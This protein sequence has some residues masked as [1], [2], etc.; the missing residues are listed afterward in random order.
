MA[1]ILQIED[2]E[3]IQNIGNAEGG[4]CEFCDSEVVENVF[5][6]FHRSHPVYACF[7]C[8]EMVRCTS[9]GTSIWAQKPNIFHYSINY[10]KVT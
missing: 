6:N 7:L 8:H 9:L 2:N 3:D 10:D 5:E 4:P 1:R